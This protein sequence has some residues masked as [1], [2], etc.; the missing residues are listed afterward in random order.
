M[1]LPRNN[2]YIIYISSDCCTCAYRDCTIEELNVTTQRES[3]ACGLHALANA[4]ALCA[5]TEQTAIIT[6]HEV[7]FIELFAV[8]QCISLFP[9]LA[10]VKIMSLSII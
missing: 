6:S 3:A 7:S 2:I 10:N 5:T 9:G 8:G 4:T 1:L